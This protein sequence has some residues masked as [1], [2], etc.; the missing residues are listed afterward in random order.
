MTPASPAALQTPTSSS[1]A[2]PPLAT[3]ITPVSACS[4]A[5]PAASTP[6]NMPSRATSVYSTSVTPAP[7]TRRATS[8]A[9]RPVPCCPARHLHLAVAG[10]D[11]RHDPSREAETGLLDQVEPLHRSGAEHDEPHA[12]RDGLL[13]RFDGS[14]PSAQLHLDAGGHDGADHVGVHRAPGPG[15]VEVDDVDAA[16]PGLEEGL[17]E[18]GRVVGVDGAGGEVASREADHLAVHEVDGG[19]DEHG[20]EPHESIEERQPHLLALLRVE[21]D[22]EEVAPAPGRRSTGAR[23]RRGAA[24]PAA[25][26]GAAKEWA[27]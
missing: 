9:G 21:L 13:D 3:T 10:V 17:G 16:R 12:D 15:A 2:T 4:R 1:E 26:A 22:G 5:A 20:S 6:V 27:K 7:A 8:T 23:A 25:S 18:L 14:E 24:T 11:A 19:N